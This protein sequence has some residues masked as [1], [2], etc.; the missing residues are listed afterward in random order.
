MTEHHELNELRRLAESLNVEGFRDL[1]EHLH[2]SDVSDVLVGLDEDARLQLIRAL[3]PELV[4]D[5]LAEMAPDEHPEE[6]LAALPAQDA[7]TI[8]DEMADDDAADL[9]GDLPSDTATTILA[10]VDD[11]EEIERLL[12]YPEDSAGGIMTSTVVAVRDTETVGEALDDIRHQS[13]DVEGFFQVYCVDASRRLLGVVPL[14][15][16][17]SSPPDQPIREIMQPAPA[18]ARPDQDQ[19]DVARLMSRYNVAAVPVVDM[20]GRLLGRVTF[21][22]VI[23][24]VEAE[25]TEDLLRFGGV[26]AE[27]ELAAPWYRAVA[28]RLPWLYVNLLTAFLPAAVV[29]I[30][31]ASTEWRLTALVPVIAGMGGNAGTQALAVTVRR[32]SLGLIPPTQARAVIGKELF[33]GFLNGFAIGSVV[34]VAAALAFGV[35]WTFGLV[36]LIAMWGNLIVAGFAGAFI[37]LLLERFGVDPAVASSVF[38]TTFTDVCGYFLLFG[39]ASAII[40]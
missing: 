9:L 37:P 32:V 11:R 35:G 38:V 7:A 18:V 28:K 40:L 4:S 24:V 6:V 8:L 10:R 29:W 15:R 2:P 22:D 27:E 12:E 16:L 31:R 21:D 33:V 1:A 30:F 39:L 13:E 19:E 34:G 20:A 5:A 36:V 3:P 25:Q 17:V 23:D 26:S 14:Q